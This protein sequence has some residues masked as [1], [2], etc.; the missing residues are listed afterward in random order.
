MSSK[1]LSLWRRIRH[2]LDVHPGL[3]TDPTANGANCGLDHSKLVMTLKT[4]SNKLRF[5]LG[6]IQAEAVRLPF[7]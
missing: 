4:K 3:I 1:E 6:S 5:E 7:Y 2:V